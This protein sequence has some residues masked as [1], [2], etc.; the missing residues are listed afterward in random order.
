MGI[1]EE[2][3]GGGTIVKQEKGGW[4]RVAKKESVSSNVA[5]RLGRLQ[6]TVVGRQSSDRLGTPARGHSLCN[7][8]LCLLLG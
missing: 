6:S 3:K 5:N 4:G 2:K 8:A 7:P 1:G